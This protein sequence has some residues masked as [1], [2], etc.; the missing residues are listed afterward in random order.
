MELTLCFI[1][2]ISSPVISGLEW[3]FHDYSGN[4]PDVIS[5]ID[6]SLGEMLTKDVKV[7]CRHFSYN[8][9]FCFIFRALF[10]GPFLFLLTIFCFFFGQFPF[11]QIFRYV[12]TVKTII[13]NILF[14]FHLWHWLL[15]NYCKNPIII[16]VEIT[17]CCVVTI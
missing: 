11:P 7:L 3:K 5:A 14:K 1:P 9:S 6:S 4:L 13:C 16:F 10:I 12:S 17:A 8:F 15:C 2:K